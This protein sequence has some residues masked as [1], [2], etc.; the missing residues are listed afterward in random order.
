[1]DGSNT[2]HDAQLAEVDLNNAVDGADRVLNDPTLY[3]YG[4]DCAR[5]VDYV[6]ELVV[7]AKKTEHST[8]IRKTKA[9]SRSCRGIS[10]STG[11][12]A[13]LIEKASR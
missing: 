7:V 3:H 6:P 12:R 1:M 2:E 4:D 9:P 11:P 8:H 5:I 10:G 13:A